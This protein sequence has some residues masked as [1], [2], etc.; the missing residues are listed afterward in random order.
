LTTT[1]PLPGL[2]PATV[3][4]P[5]PGSRAARM[6][7]PRSV[8]VVADLAADYGVCTRPVWL[9]SAPSAIGVCAGGA[10]GTRTPNPCLAKA[11]LCQLS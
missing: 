5:R 6:L 7:M 8:D 9:Y 1:P 2:T 11:V 3:E 10:Q 4:G